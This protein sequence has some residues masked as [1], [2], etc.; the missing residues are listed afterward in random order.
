[1]VGR[2]TRKKVFSAHFRPELDVIA[3]ISPA[4]MQVLASGELQRL[5]EAVCKMQD[6]HQTSDTHHPDH[7]LVRR[8]D[9]EAAL[10]ALAKFEGKS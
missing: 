4:D 5:Q 7:I 2:W 10:S 3:T 1:M 6:D 9:F 8:E